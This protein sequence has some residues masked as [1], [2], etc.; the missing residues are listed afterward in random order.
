MQSLF[1]FH[2]PFP[3]VFISEND[4]EHIY[5]LLKVAH[6]HMTVYK[7]ADIPVRF[8]YKHHRRIPPIIAIAEEHWHIMVGSKTSCK[9]QNF[10]YFI[11]F[12]WTL[13]LKRKN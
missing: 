5:Q 10:I 7:K 2:L 4:I 12:Q 1:I 8:H 3:V 13:Y 6:P 11:T 9:S